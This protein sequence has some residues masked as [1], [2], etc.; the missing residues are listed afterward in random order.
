[1]QILTIKG[2]YPMNQDNSNR[3]FAIICLTGLLFFIAQ[4]AYAQ[5]S[6]GALEKQ[7]QGGLVVLFESTITGL[8]GF[9][10]YQILLKEDLRVTP[11]FGLG[12]SPG[13]PEDDPS[14]LYLWLT[15][16]LGLNLEFGGKHRFTVS[17]QCFIANNVYNS[18]ADEKPDKSNILGPAL[19]TGY[20]LT[21]TKG[22]IFLSH[23][24][25]VY[26]HNLTLPGN[27]RRVH[28]FFGLGIG[29]KF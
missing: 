2:D 14:T 19:T 23:L 1:M 27:E 12:I 7:T 17:P 10:E 25:I 20:K 16:A 28:P 26:M 6:E 29:Y 13:G 11:F 22:F 3:R 5:K 4:P 21:T 8:S 24:G 9:V 18:P 15:N